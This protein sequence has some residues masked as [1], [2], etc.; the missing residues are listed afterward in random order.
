M[1]EFGREC[2]LQVALWR[3]NATGNCIIPDLVFLR[4]ACSLG[5]I[6]CS[7]E[8]KSLGGSTPGGRRCYVVWRNFLLSLIWTEDVS[9]WEKEKGKIKICFELKKKEV[10]ESESYGIEW[11]W[12]KRFFAVVV[13]EILL[14]KGMFVSF[15][16][17]FGK[18]S[19]WDKKSLELELQ[20]QLP[21]GRFGVKCVEFLNEIAGREGN[22]RNECEGMGWFGNLIGFNLRLRLKAL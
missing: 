16:L 10:S 18:K 12:S 22:E 6:C 1:N 9:L 20:L 13:V 21:L 8:N 7:I 4:C 19:E 15:Q 2:K 17:I 3:W 14:T 11:N 5:W